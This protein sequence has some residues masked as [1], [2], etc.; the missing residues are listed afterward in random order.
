MSSRHV[1]GYSS[2]E[3]RLYC[4]ENKAFRTNYLDNHPNV[5]EIQAQ[6]SFVQDFRGYAAKWGKTDALAEFISP[7]SPIQDL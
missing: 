1:W 5:E 4:F 3:N 2:A 6:D 7:N